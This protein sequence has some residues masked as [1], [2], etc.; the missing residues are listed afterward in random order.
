MGSFLA[1]SHPAEASKSTIA[2][3]TATSAPAVGHTEEE[4]REQH[5]RFHPRSRLLWRVRLP[6]GPA[7]RHETSHR[8]AHRL[9]RGAGEISKPL[10]VSLTVAARSIQQ[11]QTTS[12]SLSFDPPARPWAREWSRRST[13]R[14]PLTN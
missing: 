12:S 13:G 1:R 3:E 7:T 9:V 2:I 14:W 11:I 8:F 6:Q 10:A 5:D 4:V